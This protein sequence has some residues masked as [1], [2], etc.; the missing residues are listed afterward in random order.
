MLIVLYFYRIVY[1][2]DCCRVTDDFRA[3]E[4]SVSCLAWSNNGFLITAS[5]DCSVRIWK[6]PKTPWIRIDLTSSLKAE[7]EHEN[8]V[9]SLALS[10]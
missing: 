6:A 8:K 10:L 1:D 9:T 4:D 2:I 7:L 3:H 5:L